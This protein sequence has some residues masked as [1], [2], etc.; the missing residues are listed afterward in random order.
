MNVNDWSAQAVSHGDDLPDDPQLLQAVQE[1]LAQLE[2]GRHPSR[3]D[4]LH[5]YTDI[6]EPLARCLDGLELVVGAASRAGALVPLG[7]RHLPANPLGDF[8]IVREIGRGGMGIVY[9]AVQLSLGRR[10]ALKV[11]PF[12]ATFDTR[13]LQRFHNEA[14]A[15]AQL[16]HTNIVPVYAVGCERGVHFYAMQLIEGQSLAVVVRQLRQPKVADSLRESERTRGASAPQKAVEDLPT[17]SHPPSVPSIE[18]TPDTETVS[19]LSLALS[20]QRSSKDQE[21][22]RA[23]ARFIVQ[24]AEALEHAHQFGIVHRDIKPANLLVDVHGRLWITDFG[25]AQFHADAGLTQTGDILGTLRYMSPEQASGQR[26]LLDHRT[27]IY[28]LGAT[29]YE[30]VTLEPIFPGQNRQ[31]LLHQIINDEPRAPRSVEKTVPVELETII[32][33]AVSKG[34]GDRYGSAQELADDLR[35][36]LEDKPILAKRPSLIERARKWSRRHPEIVSAG[37]VLLLLCLAGLF[38]NN[39]MIAEEKERTQQ[40]AVEAEKRFQ[41]ARRA[42]DLLVQVCEEELANAP[43]HLQGV[44]Q[45][46]LESALEYY[47]DFLE[48]EQGNADVQAAL[49]E[50]RNRVRRILDEL[51]TLQGAHQLVVVMAPDVQRDLELADEQQVRVAELNKQWFDQ[52]LKHFRDR[53]GLLP[54]AKRNEKTLAAILDERQLKRLGQIALQSQGTLPFHESRVIDALHL[55]AE[56]KQK[57][58]GIEGSM[59]FPGMRPGPPGRGGPAAPGKHREDPI[60]NAVGRILQEVLTEEQRA[61]WRELIG[62]PFQGQAFF[63]PP[64]PG[65]PGPR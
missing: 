44:R 32:L 30:L 47:Q 48:Q 49:A 56:Q 4:F 16:H 43:P 57:I 5:R 11:L 38:I 53:K 8:Q 61:H 46:L 39:R 31:E 64:P 52:A 24:A 58:R 60:R 45:R 15:A 59:F 34:P 50:G 20:T 9:E 3:Q 23:A 37:V 13:Q 12:A 1:Y 26:V 62:E 51:S 19:P 33:K 54:L 14:Q 18:E 42:V 35:R 40:R 22:F 17:V 27:D 21:F 10:V 2:A 25:L 55:T 36:Y 65:R 63:P 28:A 7:S 6:A 41:Q 29:L